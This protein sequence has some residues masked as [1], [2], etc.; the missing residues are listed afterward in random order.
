M[1]I[2]KK[3]INWDDN[4]FTYLINYEKTIDYF[5]DTRTHAALSC[6][7]YNPYGIEWNPTIA[8]VV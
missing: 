3:K 6:Y 8:I 2:S 7:V 1:E 5:A 4:S